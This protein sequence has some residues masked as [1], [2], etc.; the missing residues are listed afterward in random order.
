MVPLKEVEKPITGLK[1][2]RK[3]EREEELQQ[4]FSKLSEEEHV[5][6]TYEANKKKVSFPESFSI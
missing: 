6:K 5:L 3:V 2:I 4:K 1:K